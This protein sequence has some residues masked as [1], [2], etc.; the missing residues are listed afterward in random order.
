MRDDYTIVKPTSDL[1]IT[2]ESE[3]IEVLKAM[4]AHTK[5]TVSELANTAI[6][7][8]ISAHKDFMPSD[9]YEMNMNKINVQR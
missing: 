8:F 1:N 2:I 6:R 9:F 4:E 7:R 3:V 5:I